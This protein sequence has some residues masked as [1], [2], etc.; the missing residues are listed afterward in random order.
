MVGVIL[1]ITGFTLRHCNFL[2]AK[3]LL[4]IRYAITAILANLAI[5]L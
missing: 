2:P 4:A 3:A 5:K 1:A